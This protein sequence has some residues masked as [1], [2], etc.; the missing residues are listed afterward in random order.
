MT[1]RILRAYL[2]TTYRGVIEVL[3]ASDKLQRCL[4]LKRLPHYST[5][6]YFAG[7]SDTLAIVAAML[8]EIVGQV[9]KQS[10]EQEVAI[11]ASGVENTSASAHFCTRSG[12]KRKKEVR[13]AIAVCDV[14]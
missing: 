4:G 5:L 6:K 12:R 2:K 11:D 7:R 9:V 1:C 13:E 8:A 10:G 3:D 14:W